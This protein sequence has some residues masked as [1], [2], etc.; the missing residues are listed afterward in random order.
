MTKKYTC[1]LNDKF[2]GY[3]PPEYMNELFKDYVVSC[4]M[5]DKKEVSFE[6]V[7]GFNPRAKENG[8]NDND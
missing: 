2:Y 1:Y 5:Y 8:E 7:E 3:G 6:I 4:G